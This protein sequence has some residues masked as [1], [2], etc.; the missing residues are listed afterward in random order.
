VIPILVTGTTTTGPQATRPDRS[1]TEATL[2]ASPAARAALARHY[3]EDFVCLGFPPPL[4]PPAASPTRFPHPRPRAAVARGGPARLTRRRAGPGWVRQMGRG[5][6]GCG[7]RVAVSDPDASR[8]PGR[9]PHHEQSTGEYGKPEPQVPRQGFWP[10]PG[11][12]ADHGPNPGPRTGAGL[13]SAL[14][15]GK[16]LAAPGY[17][18]AAA[19][20]PRA[21][22]S[23]AAGVRATLMPGRPGGQRA[24]SVFAARLA[25]VGLCD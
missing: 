16:A 8:H 4:P 5:G 15:G 12:R 22:G 6:G 17:A 10:K 18:P 21:R 3:R 19:A 11:P 2:Q 13:I 14:A 25:L 7:R 24:R 1:R 23:Q 20:T 9:V